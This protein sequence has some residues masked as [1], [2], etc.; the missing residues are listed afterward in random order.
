M[1]MTWKLNAS[2]DLVISGGTF[3]LVTGKDEVVQRVLVT[4]RHYW[5]EYWLNLQ[6][7]VPWYE[8]ILGRKNRKLAEIIL[9]KIILEVPGVDGISQ[10]STSFVNRLFGISLKLEVEDV[11]IDINEVLP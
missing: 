5:Q 8:L 6:G 11:V 10:F 3:Q 7:G 4:L 9:R 1:S 2:N